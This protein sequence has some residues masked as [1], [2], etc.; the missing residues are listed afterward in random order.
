MAAAK[1][2]SKGQ[3]TIPIQVR[4]ELGLESGDR[5]EFVRNPV[6][7]N[8]EIIPATLPIHALKGIVPKPKRPVSIKDMNDAIARR[9][10]PAR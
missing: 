9:G 3:I 2:T 1:V 7:G 8:Y 5:I 4:V 10:R 6:T